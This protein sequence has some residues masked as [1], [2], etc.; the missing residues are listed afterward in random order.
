MKTTDHP[1]LDPLSLDLLNLLEQADP[2]VADL[3]AAEANRQANTLELIASENHVSAAVMHAAGTWMTNKYAEGYPGKRYYGGC[4]HHDTAEDLARDRAK[5]L[6]GCNF[7]NVQPH[8]GANANIAAFMAMCNPGDRI[9]SLPI[10]SGGHLSHGLK[11]N[12][13]GTFYE[14]HDY[15]VDPESER[16][17]YDVIAARAREVQPKMIICGYSAYPR[18]IDF[19][20]FRAIADDVGAI[21]M[22]DIAHIAG[23][24]AGGAHPSPFPHA[25]IVTTTTHKTLRGPRGGLILSN[26]EDVA[27]KVDRK[28]F[29]GSQGGPLMHIIT[30]KAVAFG[31]ALQPSFNDYAAQVVSNAAALAEGLVEHGYRLCTG[32]TDNHLLLVDLQP[33]DADLTG[34]DAE[35][36]LEAAGIIT[37][38][39]GI[40]NDPR[41]PMVTSGLRLGTAAL[42]TR[43]LGTDDMRQIASWLD[44]V[45]ASKGD[46]A[47]AREVRGEIREM[48][49]AHPLPH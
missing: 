18:T 6:F 28:V 8:C 49:D 45:M 31:E 7:A 15:D 32:G 1:S 26:D 12:F 4:E 16:L 10:K 20:R 24:V 36:W 11:P 43:G 25:H 9:L 27:K 23:L 42:T 29:P 40:P 37:N 47:V 17:D 44:R 14:I 3:L 46:E 13:S 2:G 5:E 21:L 35:Q 34:A 48:C 30:A 22:A 33:R 41:P 38:K 19:E 39:N